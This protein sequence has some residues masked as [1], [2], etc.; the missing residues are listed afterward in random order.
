M[1]QSSVIDHHLTLLASHDPAI[2]HK[3]NS[4]KPSDMFHQPRRMAL[5]SGINLQ[6]AINSASHGSSANHELSIIGW[7]VSQLTSLSGI[8]QGY[9][10]AISNHQSSVI[11]QQPS[12]ISCQASA[13]NRQPSI[14][15][16]PYYNPSTIVSNGLVASHRHS[17]AYQPAMNPL[18]SH[19]T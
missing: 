13:S 15:H 4:E 11:S 6:L 10:S 12:A 8:G 19:Q 7:F 17:S 14:S 16:E 3:L 2:D 18:N 9:P 1:A 5:S